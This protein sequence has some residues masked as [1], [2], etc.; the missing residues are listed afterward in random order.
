MASQGNIGQ[1]EADITFVD[2]DRDELA[3]V[4]SY[5]NTEA[6]NRVWIPA[7]HSQ[8]TVIVCFDGTGDEFDSDVLISIP[9][10]D[11]QVT[12]TSH[13]ILISCS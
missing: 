11:Q 1:H 2:S 12:D 3:N 6:E 13:R 7:K 5:Y 4:I 10:P 9:R 8:R